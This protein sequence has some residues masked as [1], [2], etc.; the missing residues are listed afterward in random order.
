VGY[1][2]KE[3]VFLPFPV[4]RHKVPTATHTR[5]T[6]I[7]ASIAA[8]KQRGHYDEYL[9]NLPAAH[10]E[11]IVGAVAGTWLEMDVAL[12]HYTTANLLPLS[13]EEIVAIG[14]DVAAVTQK[15]TLSV[16]VRAAKS[17]GVTP[18]SMFPLL[19]KIWERASQGGGLAVFKLG[20]KEA[21]FEI[22]GWPCAEVPY[23]R[24]AW[25]GVIQGLTQLF[26]S[27]VYARE[28]PKLCTPSSLG[29]V[30]SWA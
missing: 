18:W 1:D 20:P 5:S 25:R 28:V 11:S 22:V 30:M 23:C 8:I 21:R 7:T 14:R 6:W 4:P 27:T 9:K 29:Y 17:A 12:A 16:A 15:T 2:V 13:E 26:C 10:R 19:P 3:E 24:V